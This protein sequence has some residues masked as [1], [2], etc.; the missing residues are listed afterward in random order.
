MRLFSSFGSLGLDFQGW[1]H[2]TPNRPVSPDVWGPEGS[3]KPV[4]L[5]LGLNILDFDFVSHC[6]EAVIF[7][8]V[9]GRSES[10]SFER[11]QG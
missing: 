3:H 9:W 11:M 1:T 6:L 4:G 7:L 8:R 2:E 10:T 5:Q